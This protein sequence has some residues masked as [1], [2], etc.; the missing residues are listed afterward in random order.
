MQSTIKKRKNKSTNII[1]IKGL[2]VKLKALLLACIILGST[3]HIIANPTNEALKK[4]LAQAQTYVQQN[5]GSIAQTTAGTLTF[6]SGTVITALVAHDMYKKSNERFV[7]FI[8]GCFSA[9]ATY[10]GYRTIN[11]ALNNR[12]NDI[13]KNVAQKV[14]AQFQ[15][16][17]VN[18]QK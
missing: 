10:C 17:K 12:P 4:R 6:V 9:S 16:L 18:E 2:F 14:K 8:M 7:G 1:Y 5:K 13:I 11:D 15:K 3:L